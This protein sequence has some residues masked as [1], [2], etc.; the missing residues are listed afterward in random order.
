M[1][2]SPSS[3]DVAKLVEELRHGAW[4]ACFGP[5]EERTALWSRIGGEA[6][7][8]LESLSRELAEA[9]ARDYRQMTCMGVGDGSGQLFVYGDYDSIKAAQRIVLRAE[10]AEWRL[11]RMSASRFRWVR[12]FFD[13][14]ARSV[15]PQKEAASDE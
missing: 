6:A 8:A 11:A 14:R 1:T 3:G 4:L 7:T 12:C 9:R 2:P 13:L 5:W 10:E 15:L